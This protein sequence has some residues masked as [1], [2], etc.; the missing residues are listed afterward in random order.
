MRKDEEHV[1]GRDYKLDWDLLSGISIS[2]PN[3]TIKKPILPMTVKKAILD[4]R[5]SRKYSKGR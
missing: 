2:A 4:L 5:T 3:S 1:F